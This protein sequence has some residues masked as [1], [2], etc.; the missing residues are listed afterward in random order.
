VHFLRL[1]VTAYKDGNAPLVRT[2]SEVEFGA[3]KRRLE[4]ALGIEGPEDDL[5]AKYKQP[6]A[7]FTPD[8]RR[9]EQLE[10]VVERVVFLFEGGQF[11][12]PGIRIGHK[13]AL[14]KEVGVDSSD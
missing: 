3:L 8:G 6:Y 1:D 14:P 9:L 4:T 7:F 10:D 5:A 13:S 2:Q 12:W 11:I